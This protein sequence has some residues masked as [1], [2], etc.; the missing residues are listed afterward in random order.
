MAPITQ[1]INNKAVKCLLDKIFKYQLK[2]DNSL[3]SVTFIYSKID[4]INL[5]KY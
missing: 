3:N 2:I 1:A 4:N 5:L